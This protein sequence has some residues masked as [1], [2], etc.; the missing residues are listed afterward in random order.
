MYLILK[1]VLFVYGLYVAVTGALIFSFYG[2]SD[3]NPGM[4]SDRAEPFMGE[5]YGQDRAVLIEDEWSAWLARIHIIENAA[6]SLDI[7]YHAIHPGKS[8]D[9]LFG[10]IIEAAD[11]GVTVRILMDGLVNRFTFLFNDTVSLLNN[12]KNIT[13]QFYEPFTLL[14]PWTWNNRLHD[15][16][17]IADNEMLLIGGRNINDNYFIAQNKGSAV[18]D[19]DVLVF[20]TN[21]DKPTESVLDQAGGYFDRLWS[22][23]FSK[24]AGSIPGISLLAKK[25][26]TKKE[27]TG[28]LKTARESF[29]HLFSRKIDW[30]QNAYP[31]RRITLVHN[32][33]ARFNKSPWILNKIAALLQNANSRVFIQ[34][35]YAIPTTRMQ[36]ILGFTDLDDV[37][38]SMLTNSMATSRNYFAMAGYLKHRNRIKDLVDALYEYHGDGSLHAKTYIIDDHISI[39]GSFNLDSRSAFLAT[40]S[41]L[42][43]HGEAFT[44]ALQK[45]VDSAM[46][47]SYQANKKRA[48]VSEK[49]PP[50]AEKREVPF[51]KRILV[52][53]LYIP[54]YFFDFLL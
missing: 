26:Q 8:S 33:V 35:P 41:V 7:M 39:I 12:H 2:H 23:R 38:I 45:N 30:H 11:R 24:K 42:V 34:S 16:C 46:A 32:P 50:F 9:I 44:A 4:S 31:T 53:L 49:H 5:S 17:I 43:I 36:E 37:A 25:G 52:Y 40:E 19:R 29:P 54:V 22:H 27:I 21:P 6:S 15:K 47:S 48:A 51:I 14:K 10:T 28:R 3:P 20:N 1:R 18:R 13:V